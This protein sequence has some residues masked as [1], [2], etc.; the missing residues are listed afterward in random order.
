MGLAVPKPYSFKN[1]T[2]RDF[3]NEA[4]KSK[5]GAD[6]VAKSHHLRPVGNKAAGPF[7]FSFPET[8]SL[9]PV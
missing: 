8:V 5:N 2:I 7:Y 9:L 4:V 3:N 6:L 1:L